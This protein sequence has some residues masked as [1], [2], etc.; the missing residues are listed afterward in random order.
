MSKRISIVKE[1]FPYLGACVVLSVLTFWL[2]P[3]TSIIP[4][5]LFV[6]VAFF[7]RDPPREVPGQSDVITAPADGRVMEISE[8]CEGRFLN[9][10]AVRL[11][12]FLSILDVHFN[13]SPIGGRI[14]Y[15]KYE[16]GRFKPAFLRDASTENERNFLGIESDRGKLLVVQIAGVLA[17]RIACWVRVGDEVQLGQR[18][19]MIRFGSRTDLFLP[20]KTAEVYVRPGIRVR[21]GETVIGR[22]I[23]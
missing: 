7:F 23:K 20:K 15:I 1:A 19:G 4:G 14:S 5:A 6:F 3:W 18:I 17:R 12:I 2:S 16:R 9:E 22:W 21:A 13:R 10:P 11:S 8:V